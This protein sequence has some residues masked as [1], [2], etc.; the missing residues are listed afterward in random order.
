MRESHALGSTILTVAKPPPGT[1]SDLFRE[2]SPVTMNAL[3]PGAI[4]GT[5]SIRSIPVHSSHGGVTVSSA[6]SLRMIRFS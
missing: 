3:L 5:V 4:A 1:Q 2:G 6:F